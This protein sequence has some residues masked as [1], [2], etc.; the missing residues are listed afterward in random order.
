MLIHTKDMIPSESK[1]EL[2]NLIKHC[3]DGKLW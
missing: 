1:K 2:L 3:L